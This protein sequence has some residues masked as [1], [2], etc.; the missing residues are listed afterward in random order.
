MSDAMHAHGAFGWCELMTDDVEAAKRFYAEV[1][2][3][4]MEEMDMGMGPYTVLKAGGAP[5]G[6][7]MKTPAQAAGAP[8]QWSAYITVDDVDARLEKAKAAGATVMLGP[9][10]IPT[11]GRFAVIQ[12][13]TG[14]SI[15]LITYAE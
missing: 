6:G 2:G 8:A 1:I 11:V 12:D 3:W 13:P 14:A 4:E 5:V 15:C 7:I 9:S 10:D